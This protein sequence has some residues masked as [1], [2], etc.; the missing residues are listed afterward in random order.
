VR[1][2]LPAFGLILLVPV[3]SAQQTR[4]TVDP[5]L[6]LAW[7]QINPHLNHLWATTCPQEPSWR[8]GEDRSSGPRR[9]PTGYA[10]IID[11]VV[12]LR[13]RW[14]ALPLCEPAVRGEI[15][16]ADTTYWRDT[17]GLI[18]VQSGA[19]TIGQDMRDEYARK[20]ITEPYR[21]PDIRFFI[22]SLTQVTPGDTLIA[23]VVGTF[24][25]RGVRHRTT[26]AARAWR[27]AGGLR[28]TAKFDIP[29]TALSDTFGISKIAL[30]LGVGSVIWKTVHMGVDVVLKRASD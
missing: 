19:L 26:A 24:E 4:W 17:Q 3:C 10:A 14:R 22:D 25:F 5:K 9:P 18:V 27:E 16:T 30:G 11:T 29:A 28:V 20:T 15:A 13:P 23:T 7:W 6:S 21:Y 12:P 2:L 8:P 1:Q